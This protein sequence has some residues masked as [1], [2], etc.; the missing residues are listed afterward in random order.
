[1]KEFFEKALKHLRAPNWTADDL[2]KIDDDLENQ[3]VEEWINT[4]KEDIAVFMHLDIY[5]FVLL[6]SIKHKPEFEDYCRKKISQIDK[7]FMEY[8]LEIDN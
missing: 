4:I 5:R 1:M 3:S 7:I 2:A 6:K 8:P